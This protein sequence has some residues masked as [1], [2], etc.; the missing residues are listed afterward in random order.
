LIKSIISG[1]EGRVVVTRG[2]TQ[3]NR[4]NLAAP[5]LE[6]VLSKYEGTRLGR[7]ELFAEV[8]G[9]LPG[10]LWTQGTLD[11]Y[12]IREAP[13]CDRIVVAVDPA[14]T[15]GDEADEHGIIVAGRSEDRGVVLEDCSLRGTPLDWA[16]RAVAVYRKHKADAIVAE[17][18]QGGDMVAH[19][20]RTVDDNVRVI[21]VRATRGKHVRAE[22]VA[23]LYEQG[24]IAHVGSFPELES[25]MTQ[26]TNEG[27]QGD[28]SPDRLDALVWAFS[29]LLPDMV[30]PVVDASR[31]AIP[32]R[33][34][35]WMR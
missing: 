18:N 11:T 35:G 2:R 15:A 9:D 26:M 30:S 4:A 7:Q 23:S 1:A 27:Y 14:V 13:E 22:P 10:A 6:K 8:L 32:R 17:V 29:D 3:D 5:F 12:R 16:R 19:T 33:V 28:G 20:I 21:Q 31:F 25:Q 34:G 24:R